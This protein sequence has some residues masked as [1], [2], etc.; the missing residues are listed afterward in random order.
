MVYRY[1]FPS[2]SNSTI[3]WA[4]A[5][6]NVVSRVGDNGIGDGERRKSLLF[7]F[8][9]ENFNFDLRLFGNLL[10]GDEEAE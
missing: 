8:L 6:V 2:D 9:M 4:S 3:C 1:I 10:D 7:F 5:Q